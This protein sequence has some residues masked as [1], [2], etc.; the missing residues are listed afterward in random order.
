MVLAIGMATNKTALGMQKN[1]T[2]MTNELLL[3]NSETFKI[4]SIEIAQESQRGVVSIE[5]LKQTNDNLIST[6]NSVID[7]QRKGQE[8]R[9]AAV[10]EIRKLEQDVKTALQ[11]RT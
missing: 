11:S 7:I 10:F 1:I 8:E 3:R 6:I 9:A 2:D 4:G 5:T